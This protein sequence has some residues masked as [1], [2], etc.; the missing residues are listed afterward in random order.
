M[1]KII[2]FSAVLFIAVSCKKTEKTPEGPT[3]I[4]I[5]NTTDQIMDNLIVNTSGGEFNFGTVAA[6]TTTDYHRFDKAYPKANISCLI[7]GQ[8]FKTDSVKSSDY[9]YYQYLG[10][11]KATYE[12][13]IENLAQKKL[14][15]NNVIPDSEL[16]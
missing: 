8:K 15:I 7:N 9:L 6:G 10:P 13:Y 3:D 16:K 1:K 2:L 5:R 14:K 4:R 11:M 12:I